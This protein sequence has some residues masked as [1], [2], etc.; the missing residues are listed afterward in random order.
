MA[1]V[2]ELPPSMSQSMTGDLARS[3]TDDLAPSPGPGPANMMSQSMMTPS[4]QDNDIMT[5]STSSLNFKSGKKYIPNRSKYISI[6]NTT[7]VTFAQLWFLKGTCT[8][9]RR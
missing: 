2:G 9:K 4:K 1:G 7:S 5:S 3:L 6:L 8:L